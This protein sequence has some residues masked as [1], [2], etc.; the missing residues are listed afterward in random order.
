MSQPTKDE[1]SAIMNP[2][3]DAILTIREELTC[4][5]TEPL[6][7]EVVVAVATVETF[8]AIAA[9]V[10][11]ETGSGKLRQA[12]FAEEIGARM[13]GKETIE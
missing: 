11:A 5:R 10:F 6:P 2:V 12:A 3:A 9:R 8:A 1:L 7:N 4:N 13:R